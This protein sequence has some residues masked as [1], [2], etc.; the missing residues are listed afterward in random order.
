MHPTLFHRTLYSLH[1]LYSPQCT[2]CIA[3]HTARPL[4]CLLGTHKKTALK[5]VALPTALYS[6]AGELM[7]G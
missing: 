7:E 5:I 3:P 1:S 6:Q 4:V 2:H